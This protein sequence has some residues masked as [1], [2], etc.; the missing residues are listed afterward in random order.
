MTK[1]L[2]NFF[3][4]L[5]LA[6]VLS[7]FLP[8]WAVMLAGALAAILIPLKKA[9]VFFSPFM[10]VL[11]YWSVYAYFLS[12]G[13]DFILAGKI[14]QLLQLGGSPFLL[15]LVTGI[16]GGI[17]AGVSAVFGRQLRGMVV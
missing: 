13:N 16:I 8:W 6:V 4:T 9:W 11:L 10:A 5:V 3:L 1:N 14:S 12:S 15:I 7:L 2:T 17:A